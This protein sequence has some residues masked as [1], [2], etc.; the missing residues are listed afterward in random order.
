MIS[1][2][3]VSALVLLEIVLPNAASCVL[4]Y[5]MHQIHHLYYVL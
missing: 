4:H 5:M 2:A 3:V 1:L